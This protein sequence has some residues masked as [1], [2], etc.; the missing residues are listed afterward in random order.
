M[1]EWLRR[2]GEEINTEN[3]HWARLCAECW[4]S[5]ANK[6]QNLNLISAFASSFHTLVHLRDIKVQQATLA[7]WSPKFLFDSVFFA[8]H[9]GRRAYP[10]EL[11]YTPAKP[12]LSLGLPLL[13]SYLWFLHFLNRSFSALGLN[14]IAFESNCVL[15]R[16][17]CSL[18]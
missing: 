18:N 16:T 12:E 1:R 15:A 8:F 3:P 14:V 17:S 6:S 10:R 4:E 2:K 7:F 11:H 5:Q 9:W 13:R